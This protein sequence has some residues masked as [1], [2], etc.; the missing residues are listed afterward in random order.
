VRGAVG[1]VSGVAAA[2]PEAVAA[3]VAEPTSERAS[4]VESLRAVLGRL[5]FQAAVKAALRM[6]GVP[7]RADVRAPL[8]P[9]SAAALE[10]LRAE[11]ESL[12]D[13][14]VAQLRR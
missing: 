1:A 11:V 5:P 7:V 9:L 10:R 13:L 12:V 8:R 4:L 6:R 14:R 3:L 2:F